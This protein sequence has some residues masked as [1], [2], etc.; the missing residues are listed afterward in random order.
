MLVQ[1]LLERMSDPD[2]RLHLKQKQPR[3]F[4]WEQLAGDRLTKVSVRRVQQE[5]WA[6]R[7]AQVWAHLRCHAVECSSFCRDLLAKSL[8]LCV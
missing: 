4:E 7:E 3:V 5:S 8:L 1:Q 6:E 2:E